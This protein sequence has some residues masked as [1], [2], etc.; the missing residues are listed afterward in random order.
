MQLLHLHDQDHLSLLQPSFHSYLYLSLPLV[1]ISSWQ[2][3][4][5]SKEPSAV[6]EELDSHSGSEEDEEEEE[7]EEEAVVVPA[8]AGA[9][10][11]LVKDEAAPGV[12]TI[13]L[14]GQ[15]W[16]PYLYRISDSLPFHIISL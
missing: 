10:S 4:L 13:G 9:A 6:K 11:P 7:E 1:D 15:Y 8:V 3:Q 5:D 2:Q 12:L 16:F 14:V